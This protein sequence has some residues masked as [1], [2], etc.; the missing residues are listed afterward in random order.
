MLGPRLQPPARATAR[1]PPRIVRALDR[2][3]SRSAPI[4]RP[5]ASWPAAVTVTLVLFNSEHDVP[6]CLESL[7][8]TLER[9]TALVVAVDN[10]SPDQAAA[11]LLSHWPAAQLVRA[12]QNLGFAAG[13]NLAWPRVTT[14]YW[15]LLNPDVRVPEGGIERLVAWMNRRPQIGIAS[16]EIRG[17]DGQGT[18]S[19]GRAMPSISR[20]LLELTRVHR[21][22]P[23]KVRGRL[24]RGPYWPGGDQVDVPWVPGTAMIVRRDV[25]DRIGL[26]S[27]SFFM[28]GE[29]LEWCHRA[30]MAGWSIGVCSEVTVRHAA[31]ASVA[32]T[33][34]DEGAWA[35]LARGHYRAVGRLRGRRYALALMSVD[36]VAMAIEAAHPLRS[37]ELRSRYRANAHTLRKMLKQERSEPWLT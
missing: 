11:V 5:G 4:D 30:R 26:L 3:S 15:M 18:L 33:W 10:A 2:P 22:L 25:V 29:D 17:E 20:S 14:P 37:P 35:P 31:G 28:Y 7:R 21:L 23:T 27:E 24:L 32:R 36:A 34:G 6:A 9:G 1:A 8:P 12:S 13:A 16:A 19:A